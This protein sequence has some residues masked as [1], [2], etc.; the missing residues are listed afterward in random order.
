MVKSLYLQKVLENVFW[1]FSCK[2]CWKMYF[3]D[4]V[5]LCP[6]KTLTIEIVLAKASWQH[7]EAICYYLEIN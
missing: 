4:L 5:L 2:K 6:E 1:G 3:E 7:V